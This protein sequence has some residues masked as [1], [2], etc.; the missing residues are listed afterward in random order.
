[1]SRVCVPLRDIGVTAALSADY[2]VA[3]AL[4]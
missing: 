3:F 4:G 2:G 1:M